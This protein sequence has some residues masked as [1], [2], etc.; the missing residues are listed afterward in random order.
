LD[1]QEILPIELA[2]QGVRFRMPLTRKILNTGLLN[3]EDCLIGYLPRGLGLEQFQL[4]DEQGQNLVQRILKTKEVVAS[5]FG[6]LPMT[7]ILGDIGGWLRRQKAYH[8]DHL[9]FTIQDWRDGIFAL[10]LETAKSR[11]ND[12]IAQSDRRL[13]DILYGM[14]ESSHTENI[15]VKP[16]LATAYATLAREANY[17]GSHWMTAIQVDGRMHADD[18]KI[19]YIDGRRSFLERMLDDKTGLSKP[20][21][22]LQKY[23]RQ[24]GEQVYLFKAKFTHQ[25]GLWRKIEIQGK[26]DLCDLDQALRKAFAHDTWEHMSGFWKLVARQ[27]GKIARYREIELGSLNPVGEGKGAQI[28]L[29]EIRL[30][31]GDRIKYVYDFGDWI[32]HELTLE[33]IHA[34]EAGEL[35]PR[36]V[37]RN[38]PR[39][40][41]CTECNV[42][43]EQTIA[44]WLCVECSNNHKS[45]YLLCADCLRKHNDDHYKVQMIY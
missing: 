25:S 1:E 18:W 35:Y 22:A 27:G 31:I 45:D 17:P 44:R 38:K 16:A 34:P 4:V 8:T 40:R 41:Y 43:S 12:L 36:E 7:N 10:A 33:A 2:W 19:S 24:Q 42:Q 20:Q 3:L 11:Q 29:A 6:D 26:D 5:R 15:Y 23:D 37:K 30:E 28:R 32:E 9:I 39:Y 13:M 21:T 14:L